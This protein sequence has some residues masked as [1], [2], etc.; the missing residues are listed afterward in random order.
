MM[1]PEEILTLKDMI[2]YSCQ[3][4]GDTNFI[5]YKTEAG[6]ESRSFFDLRDYSRRFSRFLDENNLRPAHVALIGKTSFEWICAFFGTVNC[7]SAAVPLAV[8]E[9]TGMLGELIDFADVNVLAFVS[10]REDV[11]HH[12]KS[13]NPNV[14]LFISLDNSSKEDDVINISDIFRDYSS[15]A[16]FEVDEDD[17]AAIC[18]T[19]GTTG[20]P[21]GVM[22]S[23]KNYVF[24]ARSVHAYLPTKRMMTVLPIHHSFCFTGNILKSILLGRTICV[25]DDFKNLISDFRLYKPDD[26]MA[27]P[28]LIKRFMLAA[29]NN[30]KAHPEKDFKKAVNDFL[31]GN[32]VEI[33]SGGAPLDPDLNALYD[34]TGIRVINGY[35]MT[36]CSPIIANNSWDFYRYGSVGKPIPCMESRFEDGELLV[37]GPSVM[38][39]Y[40]KNKEATEEAFAPDGFLHTGDLA[41]LDND[42]YLFITGRR[43]NLI[44]L[45]NGEN[46]S[47]EMLE[48]HFANE[49]LVSEC[50]CY[51]EGSAVV[52]EFFPNKQFIA[53]N[54]VTDLDEAALQMLER[55]NG[56]LASFQR[57]TA[58]VIRE[59]P[60]EH[61][62]SSKIKRSSAF[63][64]KGAKR[65][66][67]PPETDAERRVVDAVKAQLSLSEVSIKD[68]FFALGGDSLSAMELAVDLNVSAQVIYDNPFLC[69]L[70]K[71][72]E[73]TGGL[74]EDKIENINEIIAKT[75]HGEKV[76][77][78]DCVLLTGATGFLGVHILSEILKRDVK[79]ICLVRSRQR[80]EKHF[81]YYFGD[82]DVSGVRLVLG[83]IE[84]EHFGLSETAY[85]AL[86]DEVDCVF[87]VAA[88]VHH[89]GDYADLERTNVTGT[90]NVIAF[91]LDAD[92]VLQH[93]ST[94]SL[95]GA[96]TTKQRYENSIF[97]E[98]ILDICQRYADNVYIHSKYI[99]EQEV[100]SAR[101]KGLKANIYRIGNLTWRVSDGLFQK[102]ESDNGFLHRMKAVLKLG[103]INEN[104]DKFP[105][106][107][108]AVDECARGFV[109]LAFT[110]A[111]NEIFHMFNPNYLETNELFE[112]LDRPYRTVSTLE[113]IET[114]YANQD[115]R[116]LHVYLFYLIISAKSKNI[117]MRC[118][119]TVSLLRETGFE[120]SEPTASYLKISPDNDSP[121]HILDFEPVTLKPMRKS[122]NALN[123][124][125]LI[126]LG[127]MKDAKLSDPV[128]LE[129][130]DALSLLGEKM[131]AAGCRKP[132][133]VTFEYALKNKNVEN[134]LSA[135]D[136]Y[137]ICTDISSDPGLEES[138]R[139]LR[140]YFSGGCDCVLAIGGGSV[141][142][143]SKI[144]ALRAANPGEVIDDI[145]KMD[146]DCNEGVPFF[147]VPTTAGTGSE[148][149]VFA[150]MTDE[151]ENKKKPFVSDKFLPYVVALDPTLTVSVPKMTTAFTGIDA[152]SHAVEAFTSQFAV[153]FT[154][155]RD[156]ACPA[157][158]K[159]FENLKTCVE[160]PTDLEARANMQ[161][162]AFEAGMAF[163]RISTA[164]VHAIAHRIGEK[165]HVP[166]GL[167]IAACMAPV[168]RASMP[169]NSDALSEMSIYCGF[170]DRGS[171]EDN[172]NAF[173][174]EIEKLI[175]S[176][177]IE[178]KDVGIKPED[179][180]EIL[181]RAQEEAKLTGYP[182]PF[183]DDELR[184]IIREIS[185]D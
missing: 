79:V 43:K 80:F 7:S 63:G 178:V 31:G 155:D 112:R 146:S 69:D 58:F 148:V 47:A 119:K 39:G 27:V 149:T 137:S 167:A 164:Y 77:D 121:G 5:E 97:D 65:K 62:A 72:I 108:T 91:C 106:D 100:I 163:R 172:A 143:A 180:E 24:S 67:V 165:Y 124:I 26:I 157:A 42:G 104:M 113:T 162:A 71:E 74:F 160:N 125:Q 64:L 115:D 9:T 32:M 60:F 53:E 151:E 123:P 23:H 109:S 177:G 75:A 122:G 102:N 30:A 50:I 29:I 34:S 98:S 161:K 73:G 170:E 56:K 183:S 99:A 130:V 111:T 101:L 55:V 138:E 87:H 90:K 28:A 22:T 38:R 57:I 103:Q 127:N 135:F 173:I 107:L 13:T 20:F 25:N 159:I 84:K 33:V 15:D 147:A 132:M 76:N 133:V 70:A 78:Y 158:K 185:N 118:D 117:E 44:L 48:M 182:R 40:Y 169:W 145:T 139:L 81:R 152:L 17:L 45:E 110:G 86:C 174:V 18:F 150:V 3:E 85:S 136:S 184:V 114:L 95:H 131:G 93:T 10:A 11:Y 166:H 179:E 68:N 61:T 1:K 49:E 4:Y 52:V 2:D 154:E 105:T 14:K 82:S 120:W 92:A 171:A 16:D 128:L 59:V 54:A 142:D 41:Y 144:L 140:Q 21:K 176:V 134:L 94:V 36:E 129:G 156:M 8:N 66:I 89:A 96:G 175:A 37:R 12:V 126:T 6:I 83:N 88:N 51:S 181:F 35:G 116:D 19:S 168:L 153:S 141:L 46:V